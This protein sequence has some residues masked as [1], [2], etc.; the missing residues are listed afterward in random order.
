MVFHAETT[1]E[2]EHAITIIVRK[3]RGKR[4]HRKRH[5]FLKCVQVP[6]GTWQYFKRGI[7][8]L[9]T[10]ATKEE[11]ERM[12]KLDSDCLKTAQLKLLKQVS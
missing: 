10:Y 9:W 12:L 5:A 4:Q 11:Y 2:V 1:F 6:N 8:G 3:T 7:T